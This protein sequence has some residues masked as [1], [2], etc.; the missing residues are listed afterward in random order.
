LP[1]P[2]GVGHGS[3][4]GSTVRRWGRHL[5]RG[6]GTAGS[7]CRVLALDLLEQLLDA[8]LVADGLVDRKRQFGHPA[9]SQPLAERPAEK[10]QRALERA[11]RS[12]GRPLIAER[13]VEH[14][15]LQQVLGHAPRA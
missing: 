15:R 10:R 14:A 4:G 2:D 7:V 8:C 6:F 9:Q 3:D 13:R 1:R 11:R 5:G 12:S